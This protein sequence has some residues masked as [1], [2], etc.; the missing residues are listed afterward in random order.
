MRPGQ[1]GADLALLSVI[2]NERISA[3]FSS[4]VVASGDRIFAQPCVQLQ[5]LGCS[6]TVASNRRSLSRRLSFA[7]RDVIYLDSNRASALRV[8]A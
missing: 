3:R 4:V 6:V 7:V 5:Q 2:T 1:D 8:A